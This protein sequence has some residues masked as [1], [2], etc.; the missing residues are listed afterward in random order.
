MAGKR[1]DAGVQSAAK[2]I[3]CDVAAV[4]AVI[5]VESAGAGFR[6]DGRPK[7]LFESHIFSRLT[8]GRYDKPHPT[9]ST[10]TPKRELYG[11]DQYSRF[12]QALQLN[13]EAAIQSCSWGLMQ[14]MGFNWAACGEASLLG[15]LM[16]MHHNED[17][18]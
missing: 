4:R 11:L 8:A 12:Y 2:R 7:I 17:A 1:T 13:A 16:A 10:P 15:F 6:D 14:I 5:E 3:G 9:L 18:H